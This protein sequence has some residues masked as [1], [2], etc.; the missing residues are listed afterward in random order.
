MEPIC[1]V[2]IADILETAR[3]APSGDNIQPWRFVS[4]G[5]DGLLLYRDQPKDLPEYPPY[6]ITGTYFGIGAMIENVSIVARHF[7]FGTD[8]FYEEPFD[9]RKDLIARI[10]FQ[11]KFVEQDPENERLYEAIRLRGTS[12]FPYSR[13][14]LDTDLLRRLDSMVERSGGRIVWLEGEE[15]LRETGSALSLHDD[16]YW[17]HGSLPQN[18]VKTVHTDTKARSLGVGMPIP[19][20]GLGIIGYFL[21]LAFLLAN[22]FSWIWKVIAWQSKRRSQA[23]SIRSG[24]FGFVLFPKKSETRVFDGKWNGADHVIGGRAVERLWL[25]STIERIGIQP[26]Y[27]FVAMAANEENADI[28]DR[29]IRA[30]RQAMR[31]LRKKIPEIDTETLVF[32]FRA[33]YPLKKRI[34]VCPRKRVS[35]IFENRVSGD[36]A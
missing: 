35:Q 28:G 13:R 16:F 21:P 29:F 15:N 11:K 23:L 24:A 32:A 31:F 18:L 27:A 8:V 33:G 26:A 22:H 5:T 17:E 12:R 7:G 14:S 2:P 4:N 25:L 20:L 34:P 10:K 36:I 30:N 1:K 6:F 3:F 9:E 19:T